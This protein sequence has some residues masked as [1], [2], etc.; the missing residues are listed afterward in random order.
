MKTTLLVLILISLSGCSTV[1]ML[2]VGAG[3]GLQRSSE[4]QQQR[5]ICYADS[6]YGPG[7]IGYCQ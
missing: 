2:M 1:G 5:R 7:I 6:S 3:N 4:H